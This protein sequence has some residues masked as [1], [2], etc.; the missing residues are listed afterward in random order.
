M[1]NHPISLSLSLVAILGMGA[2]TSGA[3][4]QGTVTFANSGITLISFG[5]GGYAGLDTGAIPSNDAAGFYFGLL[6]STSSAGP[7]SF[8]GVYATNSPLA[9]RIGPNYYTPTVPGWAPGV[10]MY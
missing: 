3:L 9:G 2:L 8:T 6:T 4:A 10:T 7:F 1:K 5:S